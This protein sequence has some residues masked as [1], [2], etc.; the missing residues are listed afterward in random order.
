MM[1]ND[2]PLALSRPGTEL[3]GVTIT[4]EHLGAEAGEVLLIPVTARVAAGAESGDQLPFRATGPAPKGALCPAAA[5]FWTRAVAGSMVRAS[6]LQA[7]CLSLAFF[8]GE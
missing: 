4:L 1:D 5:T 3:A 6:E 2:R 8:V 7:S